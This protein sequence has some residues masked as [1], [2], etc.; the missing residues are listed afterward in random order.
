M[1]DASTPL[2]LRFQPLDDTFLAM[3]DVE[4]AALAGKRGADPHASF[5]HAAKRL[6]Y[7]PFAESDRTRP[8]K[9]SAPELQHGAVTFQESFHPVVAP[10]AALHVP[11]AV[12][13]APAELA[14]T[15]LG[16]D[17]V[18]PQS[19]MLTS[20]TNHGIAA[21]SPASGEVKAKVETMRAIPELSLLDA[22]IESINNAKAKRSSQYR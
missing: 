2:P 18:S 11:Q 6:A 16:V 9:P 15:K 20:L 7:D 22:Q 1:T 3:L 5:E 8:Q 12:A 10:V 14:G 21:A 4:P 13:A 19:S 17:A